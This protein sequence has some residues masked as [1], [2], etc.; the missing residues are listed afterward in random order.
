MSDLYPHD[1]LMS[2]LWEY[3]DAEVEDG[4]PYADDDAA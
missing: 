1:E 4:W 2:L 3:L